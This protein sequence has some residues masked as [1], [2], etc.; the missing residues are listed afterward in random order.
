MAKLQTFLAAFLVS[1]AIGGAAFAQSATP[2]TNRDVVGNWTLVITPLSEKTS[3]SR[4][5]PGTEVSLTF[6]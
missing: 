1:S 2:I 3:A 5:N 4:S 6:P